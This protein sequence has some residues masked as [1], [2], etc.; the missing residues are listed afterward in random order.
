MSFIF[1]NCTL[2]K[3]H[4]IL[5]STGDFDLV[6][7]MAM[8]DGMAAPSINSVQNTQ[9]SI[10]TDSSTSQIRKNFPETWIWLNEM[11]G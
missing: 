10:S 3:E 2:A 4:D 1:S 9:D 7:Q 11:V 6:P 5:Y 8:N